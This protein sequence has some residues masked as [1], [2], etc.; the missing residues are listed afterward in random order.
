MTNSFISHSI[1]PHQNKMA[2]GKAHRGI[3]KQKYKLKITTWCTQT[4]HQVAITLEPTSLTSSNCVGYNCVSTQPRPLSD[5]S[6]LELAA[7]NRTVTK[8]KNDP[9]EAATEI[10]ASSLCSVVAVVRKCPLSEC[11]FTS[12]LR[13]KHRPHSY[14]WRYSNCSYCFRL[15]QLNQIE[16]PPRQTDR[17]WQACRLR[18][19]LRKM[20]HEHIDKLKG[21]AHG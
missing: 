1:L 19:P 11:L 12:G 21:V 6:S 13:G 15:I 16:H 10:V 4:R 14:S 2:D 17:N 3:K 7:R 18:S 5:I 20:R 9:F 8:T